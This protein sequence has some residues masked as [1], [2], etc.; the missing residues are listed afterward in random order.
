[1]SLLQDGLFAVDTD[2]VP[3]QTVSAANLDDAAFD[4]QLTEDA[5]RLPDLHMDKELAPAVNPKGCQQGF[6]TAKAAKLLLSSAHSE[7]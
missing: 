2:C 4:H 6:T 1:M 5:S 3:P 7:P